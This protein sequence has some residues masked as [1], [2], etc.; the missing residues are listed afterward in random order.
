ARIG[1][2]R[3]GPSHS[4]TRR[5]GC[6]PEPLREAGP[7]A[8]YSHRRG[9]RV[10]ATRGYRVCDQLHL[11]AGEPGGGRAAPVRDGWVRGLDLRPPGQGRALRLTGSRRDYRSGGRG[12]CGAV[13]PA[14]GHTRDRPL[15][16][17]TGRNGHRKRHEH[18]EPHA[19]KGPG[20][21]DGAAAQGGGSP[22]ARSDQPPGRLSHSKDC[23]AQ[24]HATSNRLHEDDGD[25]LST[26]GDGRHD[27]RWRRPARGSA[28]ADSG[29][30]HAPRERLYSSHPGWAAILPILLHHSPPTTARSTTR[31]V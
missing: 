19:R 3:L 31:Q 27:H 11:R 17:T 20:R 8:R 21:P 26:G 30:V 18:N 7:G 28:A 2:R 25:Y 4:R 1:D 22:G 16:H 5:R 10:R 15:P 23:A 24:R 12:Y 13:A 29:H 6:G 9:P 14:S